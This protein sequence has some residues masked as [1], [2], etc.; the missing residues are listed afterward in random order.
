MMQYVTTPGVQGI[1]PPAWHLPTD[2]DWKVLEGAADSQYGVG[3]PEWDLE[4][5]RGYNAGY[6]LKSTSGWN[7]GGNGNDSFGF[8]ILPVGY[9]AIGLTFSNEFYYSYFWSSTLVVSNSSNCR[10]FHYDAQGVRRI[11]TDILQGFSVRCIKD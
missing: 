5:I 11:N 6:N 9:R 7:S 3:D 4:D 2:D 8:S 1:C 10:G